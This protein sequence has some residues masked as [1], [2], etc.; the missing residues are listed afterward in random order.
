MRGQ[1]AGLAQRQELDRRQRPFDSALRDGALD[2][3]PHLCQTDLDFQPGQASE[4]FAPGVDPFLA[5]LLVSE[6]DAQPVPVDRQELALQL[7]RPCSRQTPDLGRGAR[8]RSR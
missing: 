2:P 6:S 5:R 4:H 8:I 1:R 7:G 3:A